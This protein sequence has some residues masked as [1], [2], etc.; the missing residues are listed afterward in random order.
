VDRY[1]FIFAARKEFFEDETVFGTHLW[2]Q[3]S[4]IGYKIAPNL[5]GKFNPVGECKNLVFL[6]TLDLLYFFLP[7]TCSLAFL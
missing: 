2:M 3:T 4:A 5:S 7:E 6:A 1:T